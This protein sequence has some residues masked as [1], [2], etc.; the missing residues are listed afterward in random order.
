M[1]H[2]GY[3]TDFSPPAPVLPL[4][5]GAPRGRASVLLPALVDS[6]ADITVVP[7][8]LAVDLELPAVGS[9]TVYGFG[10]EALPAVIYAATLQIGGAEEIAEVLAVGDEG[11]VGRDLLNRWRVT[12]DGP[13]L[14]LTLS[15]R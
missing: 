15:R 4:R 11:L 6:G 2:F 10:G 9:M 3:D 8:Q 7:L 14:R 13:R 12:L 1:A 5:D